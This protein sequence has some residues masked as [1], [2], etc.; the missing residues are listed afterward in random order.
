MRLNTVHI[1]GLRFKLE[2]LINTVADILV[3]V[4]MATILIHR[5]IAGKGT[6]MTE[7]LTIAI[8]EIVVEWEELPTGHLIIDKQIMKID[9]DIVG[10]TIPLKHLEVAIQKGTTQ[11]ILRAEEMVE[12]TVGEELGLGVTSDQRI[13]DI[14]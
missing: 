13:S 2:G 7:L 8:V 6:T 9:P 1:K 4:T 14:G 12:D 5:L 11:T 3:G 10:G